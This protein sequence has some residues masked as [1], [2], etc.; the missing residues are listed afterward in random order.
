MTINPPLEPNY[1][2]W[3]YRKD[4]ENGRTNIGAI[5]LTLQPD[6]ISEIHEL[7]STPKLKE[8][9]YNLNKEKTAVMTLGCLIEESKTDKGAWYSYV[10]FCFRPHIDT[11]E[12]N[13][14]SLDDQFLKYIENKYSIDFVNALKPHVIWES[15]H[16]SL[17]DNKPSRVYSVFLLADSAEST[18]QLYLLLVDWFHHE[19]LHLA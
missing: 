14:E 6:R 5:D 12:V 3:P 2:K 15:F 16:A 10:D 7:N 9:I 1:Q 19:F 17:Y 8:A 13:M 11:S 4:T 18:E